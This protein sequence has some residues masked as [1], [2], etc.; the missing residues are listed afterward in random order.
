[1]TLEKFPEVNVVYAEN[2]PEYNPLP[3]H[4]QPDGTLTCCW[5]L[6]WRE[7]VN[8]LLR[9]RVW[10]Q[11]LTFNHLLQPQL[12]LTDKPFQVAN[13]GWR[14]RIEKLIPKRKAR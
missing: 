3:A 12:L 8:V 5:R 4:R 14:E 10:H 2:Q 9:G 13:S 6:T 1:M 11:I 7:R